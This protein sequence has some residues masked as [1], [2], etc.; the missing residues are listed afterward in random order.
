[1]ASKTWHSVQCFLQFDLVPGLVP[2]GSRKRQFSEIL[3]I[4][5]ASSK[6]SLVPG[7]VPLGSTMSRDCEHSVLHV[8]FHI[9]GLVLGLVPF[10]TG[11]RQFI[12]ILCIRRLPAKS[13]WF[14]AWFRLVP[15]CPKIVNIAFYSEVSKPFA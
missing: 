8:V 11:K 4:H 3:K 2:P 14:L 1:M 10:V 12:E 5:R 13:I 15:P 9:I 7:L 6:I